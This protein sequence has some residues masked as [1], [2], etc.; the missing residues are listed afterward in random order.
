LLH[1]DKVYVAIRRT[2]GRNGGMAVN[3]QDFLMLLLYGGG[4]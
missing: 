4:S 1:E 3:L 2:R